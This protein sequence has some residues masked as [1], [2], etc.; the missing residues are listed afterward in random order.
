[1]TFMA[2]NSI[3]GA[4]KL[5][6]EKWRDEER[7]AIGTYQYKP[8]RTTPLDPET[9]YSN[10]NFA[11]GYMAVVA[12]VEVDTETGHVKVLDVISTND[13][14]KAIN[15]QQVEGQIEGAIVQAYGYT[16]LENFIQKNGYVLTDR[17]ATYLT[18]SI[19]DIPEKVHINILEYP[20]PIGPYGA[21]GIG[22]MPY[23][24]LPAAVISAVQD[25]CGTWFNEFPLTPDRVLLGLRKHH[26]VR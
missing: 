1:M 14:G 19:L 15:P 26:P 20:A 9:G 23:L 3:I 12:A 17:F 13:V 18:P 10:P 4:A 2:G 6:L 25:A 21:R 7:P 24:P 11:Y 8:R 22:E 16:V 5:A